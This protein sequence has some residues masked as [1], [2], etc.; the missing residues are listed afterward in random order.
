MSDLSTR[1]QLRERF[2]LSSQWHKTK[3]EPLSGDASFRRYFRLRR[4]EKS[5]F[6]LM[7]APPG[8]EDLPSFLQVASYL[9]SL[10][11]SA[12][13]VFAA[14][15]STGFAIIEDFG[16]Q[17]YTRLIEQGQDLESLYQ[18]AVDVLIELQQKVEVSAIDRPPYDFN[19]LLQEA[20]LLV[21]WYLPALTGKPTDKETRRDY[22]N[23]WLS[24]FNAM[25]DYQ[26]TLVL[27]DYHVDNLMILQNRTGLQRCGLLDFQDAVIGHPAYDLASLLEDARR[28][29]ASEL[30]DKMLARYRQSA[31]AAEA[32]F[33]DWYAVLATQRHAKVAGIF[34]RLCLR[35]GK[36]VY[37]PHIPRVMRMLDSHL[38]HPDLSPIKKWFD[39]YLPDRLQALPELS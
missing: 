9:R 11:L 35:D 39:F 26:P 10:N 24:V 13:E 3:L 21:D 8:K 37:L 28:D 7:D 1:D 23:A 18:L 27:R 22:Q 12:P 29:V 14:D 30:A 6:L 19:F 33:D 38:E 25:P 31:I 15:E 5:S 17:T 4:D 32:G 36:P 16:E 2:L 34:V 20:L